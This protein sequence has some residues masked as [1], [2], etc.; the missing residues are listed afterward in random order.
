LPLFLAKHSWKKEQGPA[1]TKAV[2]QSFIGVASGTPPE[3]WPETV[4]LCFTY[5]LPEE[6]AICIWTADKAETLENMFTAMLDI[7]P[8]KTTITPI[9]QAYPPS[10]DLY[11]MMAQM[12]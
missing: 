3:Q 5:M 12:M 6:Q 10:G 7:F 4:S 8:A 11:V 9:V 2:I 1:I